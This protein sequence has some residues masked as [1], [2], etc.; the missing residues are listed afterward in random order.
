MGVIPQSAT[1]VGSVKDL[2]VLSNEDDATQFP[3]P[4]WSLARPVDG[5]STLGLTPRDA[6]LVIR[7][8]TE[9]GDTWPL[10]YLDVFIVLMSY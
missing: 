10:F 7:A 5:I 1:R 4:R 9:P 6:E 2:F 3:I 8:D